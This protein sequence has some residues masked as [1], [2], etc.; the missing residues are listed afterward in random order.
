[1]LAGIQLFPQQ[2]W[3]KG[4]WQHAYVDWLNYFLCRI[5]WSGEWG[6]RTQEHR[7]NELKKTIAVWSWKP[8]KCC[9]RGMSGLWGANS[10]RSPE[11]AK[12]G[13]G[14]LLDFLWEA[15]SSSGFEVRM[16]W[17]PMQL[18]FLLAVQPQAIYL[19][20]LNLSFPISKMGIFTV[21]SHSALVKAEWDHL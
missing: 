15:I 5:W 18:H 19:T 4:F 8:T 9:G 10:S 3:K 13:W 21:S 20:S 11:A 2:V 12:P 17:V 14:A 7:V 6:R 1:M 16:S